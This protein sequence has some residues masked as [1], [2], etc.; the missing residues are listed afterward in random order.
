MR[1][2]AALVLAAALLAV[3]AGPAFAYHD[4]GD[5]HG[6]DN[7]GEYGNGNDN[8]RCR[9]DQCRG[10]FSPGPFDRSPVDV[11]D[12]CVSLDCSAGGKKDR[13]GPPP[14]EGRPQ[15]LTDPRKL[16]QAI[17]QIIKAGLDLGKMFADG[18]IAFIET[19]FTALA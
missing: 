17:Q 8:R 10:S 14:A 2:V 15:S 3:G 9:G 6:R 5:R 13:E 1:R 12:N 4:D 16:P 11:H 7:G 18:T 19:M